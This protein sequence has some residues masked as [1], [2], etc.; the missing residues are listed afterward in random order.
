MQ[1]DRRRILKSL[2]VILMMPVYPQVLL[3]AAMVPKSYSFATEDSFFTFSQK[4]L[5]MDNL[6]MRMSNAILALIEKEPWGI[7][8]LQRVVKKI[9]QADHI[10]SFIDS[11]DKGEKWFVGHLLT[12]YMTGIY[13]HELGNR[14]VSYEH[15]VMH[16]GVKDLRPIPGLSNEDFGY[17]ADLPSAISV[18]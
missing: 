16:E 4:L 12:T 17:W 10:D 8:H 2:A 13:Y 11:L 14:V 7:E 18:P 9:E 3:S 15:A 6:N 1:E 5:Q